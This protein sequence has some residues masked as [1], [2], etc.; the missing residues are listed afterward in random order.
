M[1]GG[2]ERASSYPERGRKTKSQSAGVLMAFYLK[3]SSLI[4]QFPI[5]PIR[6]LMQ[7]QERETTFSVLLVSRTGAWKD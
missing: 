1:P 4:S 7:G 2:K 6:L 3:N 5:P